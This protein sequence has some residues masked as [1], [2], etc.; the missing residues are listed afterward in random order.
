MRAPNRL[1]L[2][3]LLLVTAGCKDEPGGAGGGAPR[4]K[5]DAPTPAKSAAPAPVAK[6]AAAAVKVE[7]PELAIRAGGT[8]KVRVS[9]S[10]P[11]G[12]AVNEEAPFRVRWNRSD[13]ITD[14][15][16]D[17]K[18]TGSHAKDGFTV[19]VTPTPGAPNAVLTGEIDLVV[20]DVETHAV[21][22]PVKR[23][24]ELGFVVVKNGPEEA[25]VTIPLPQAKGS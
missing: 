8:S 6:V 5:K 25:K 22:L 15:P 10:S 23:S 3:L 19:D 12:T 11:A 4:E 21:C 13:G 9:W 18:A 20:C 16:S 14:A 7:I 2:G 17:V 1:L 24:L